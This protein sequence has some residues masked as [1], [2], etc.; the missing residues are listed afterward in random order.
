MNAFF[1]FSLPIATANGT[2]E[3][4]LWD[5]LSLNMSNS[6]IVSLQI[7]YSNKNTWF[8]SFKVMPRAQDSCAY[9]NAGFCMEVDPSNHIVKSIPSFVFGGV[10]EHTISASSTEAYML[11]KCVLDVKVLKNALHILD[12]EI[13]PNVTP[14][15]ASVEFRKNCVLSLF[16]KFILATIEDKID[17]KYKS[18]AI[19]YI[20][21]VSKGSQSYDTDSSL[22]LSLIHI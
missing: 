17:S 20:R 14:G 18:A 11:G 9:V 19:Q 7:P 4:P 5:F 1:H 3:Y 13:E 2:G 6:V 15:A 16:Y 10:K 21:P 22:Y 12:N 8:R